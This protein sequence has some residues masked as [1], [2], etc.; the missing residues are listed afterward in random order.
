MQALTRHRIG[1]HW[2]AGA[3]IGL[4]LGVSASPAWPS[5]QL[6]MDKGCY[7]CHGN[8]PRRDTPSFAALATEYA[9]ARDQP[10]ALRAWVAKLRKGSLFGHIAAHERLSDDEALR[11]VRWIAEGAK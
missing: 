11:L 2:A 5:A 4:A 6:A 9:K 1:K 7:N 8:P 3:W 10:E